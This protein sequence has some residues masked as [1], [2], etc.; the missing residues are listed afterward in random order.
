MNWRPHVR[1]ATEN[2]PVKEGWRQAV[3]LDPAS[4]ASLIV[5][6]FNQQCTEEF[7]WDRSIP[8]R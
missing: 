7:S 2:P 4:L 1:P 3:C 5:T 6:T 8:H